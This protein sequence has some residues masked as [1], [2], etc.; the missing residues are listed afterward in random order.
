[1]KWGGRG[2]RRMREEME[3]EKAKTNDHLTSYMVTL[4]SRNFL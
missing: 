4:N 1:M 3:G 2:K